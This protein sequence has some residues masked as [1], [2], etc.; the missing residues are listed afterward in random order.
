MIELESTEIVM[1]VP[2]V[3]TSCNLF[4]AFVEIISLRFKHV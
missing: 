3:V 1:I 2:L 4:V